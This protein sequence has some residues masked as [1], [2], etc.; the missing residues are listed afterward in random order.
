MAWAIAATLDY[1]RGAAPPLA[2]HQYFPIGMLDL[3][4]WSKPVNWIPPSANIQQGVQSGQ[5]KGEWY[6]CPPYEFYLGVMSSYFNKGGPRRKDTIV[7]FNYDTVVEDTLNALGVPFSYGAEAFIGRKT[8]EALRQAQR[9][10]IRVLKLHGSINWCSDLSDWVGMGGRLDDVPASVAAGRQ[11]VAFES[12]AKLREIGH[13]P[14][15]VAPTWQ[16][17]LA[18]GLSAIWSDAVDA[19]RSA[20]NVIILG[21]SM[22]PTDQHFKYFLAAG[23][24]DNISVRKVFFVNP[25][26]AND[27]TKKMLE[28]RVFSL[29]RR[30]LFDQGIV[31]FV[32]TDIREFLAGPRN[33]G[34]ESCR[35][36]I[37]RPLNGP[38]YVW[39]TAPWTFYTPFIEGW[40]IA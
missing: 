13:T 6:G 20:T 28:E 10:R 36:R 23:L 40:S 9:A 7:T 12:Y 39:G 34:Q 24:Q 11:I 21:Y 35:V 14:L 15:L 30:E 1:S 22:P 33:I 18:G 4:G 32:P 3:A 16:K 5:L 8:P 31:E 25:A 37:G 26:L 29:F 27:E 19:L 38:G 2:E 17:A